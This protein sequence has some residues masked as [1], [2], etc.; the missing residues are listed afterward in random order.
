MKNILLFLFLLFSFGTI[1][2]VDYSSLINDVGNTKEFPGINSLS[3]FDSTHVDVKETGLSYVNSHQLV[4]ILTPAGALAYSVIKSDY[5][6]L[7]A[8]VI[9]KKVIVYKKNGGTIAIDT[10]KVLDYPAPAGTILWGSRERMLEVGRLEPGDAVE[11]FLFRKGFTYA[12][13]QDDDDKYIPPMKGQFYD[14]VPFWTSEAIINKTYRINLPKTKF[15]QY[16]FYHGDAQ[17]DST[18]VGDQKIFTFTKMNIGAF[19]SEPNMVAVS[20][21]APKLLLS[22]S[23][24]WKAKSR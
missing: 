11:I 20:D 17:I 22:T 10:S 6:P 1:A 14:I 21:V 4:K 16:K 7:S 13:L 19:K 24:D 5:D 12:L 3:I 8:Y 2:Q 15:L 23:P 9:I 18:M